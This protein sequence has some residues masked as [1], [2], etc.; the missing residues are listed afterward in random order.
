MCEGNLDLRNT[1]AI[2]V[3][4]F[5]LESSK[6]I[7]VPISCGDSRLVARDSTCK[8]KRY[9]PVVLDSENVIHML[10]DI[11]RTIHVVQEELF[12]IWYNAVTTPI[13]IVK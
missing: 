3:W 10:L 4:S 13:S 1:K 5:P 6:I 9:P 12:W 11:N 8:S 7:E 2:N